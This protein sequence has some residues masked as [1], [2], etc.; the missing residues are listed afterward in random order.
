M[1]KHV[2]HMF[3]S[4]WLPGDDYEGN[5]FVVA[6]FLAGKTIFNHLE[7]FLI[8]RSDFLFLCSGPSGCVLNISRYFGFS[9]VVD[10]AESFRMR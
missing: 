10:L 1:I 4:T 8:I 7:T 5:P 9:K 2:L 3:W 6:N